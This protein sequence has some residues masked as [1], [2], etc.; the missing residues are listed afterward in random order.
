MVPTQIKEYLKEK[1]DYHIEKEQRVGGGSI[2]DAAKVHVKD[3]GACFLKWNRTA[4]FSMF[5]TE[6]KG[7]K[8]LEEADSGL[9][10]PSPIDLAIEPKSNTGYL[11]MEY[12]EQGRPK[13]D[14]HEYFGRSLAEQ[15]KNINDQH[16]LDHDNYIGRLPQSNRKRDNWVE[17]FIEERLVPQFKMA[18]DS[19]YFSSD[20]KT[21]DKLKERLPELMP[22]EPAGLLHGDLW[23]GNYF[24]TSEGHPA[25]FDPA[26][27][28]GSREIELAFTHMF[29]GFSGRFYD[30]YEEKYPLEPGFNDRIDLYNLYPLLVHTNLFGGGY[31]R[32]VSSI[33]NRYT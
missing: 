20:L 24:Y 21:F 6:V 32:E 15:H 28:Y 25:I 10:I 3:L 29:G 11:L 4:D 17:F 22:Q 7:L 9:V 31:A 33:M 14:G 12:L 1:L 13:G 18:R 30:A 8:L 27:Y 16:G 2:N 23:G 5:Q 19:G 26:V